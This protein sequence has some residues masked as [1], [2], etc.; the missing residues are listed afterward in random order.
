MN[1]KQNIC[2]IGA[3]NLGAALL[4]H[5]L[6][7]LPMDWHVRV[8]VR[9]E[10]ARERWLGHAN[11]QV[12]SSDDSDA[13]VGAALVVVAVKPAQVQALAELSLPAGAVLVSV[14]AGV[15][16]ER[17]QCMFNTDALV[18]AMPNTPVRIGRGITALAGTDALDVSQRSLAEAFFAR[19]GEVLWVEEAALDAVTAVSGSGPAYFF[20][21]AES[22]MDAAQQAGLTAD[23]ARQLVIA[24]ASG[25]AGLLGEPGADPAELRR[26]VTSE[27]GTTEAALA[28]FENDGLRASVGAAIAAAARRAAELGAG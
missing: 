27:G 21:L 26:A 17:L 10:R 2:L 28:V 9:S 18:R 12:V 14:V 15:S 6:Q 8:M 13:L 7:A 3:G 24:T 25:A 4:E 5:L 22:M 19:V 16:L 11:L 20:L 23:Q 1:E